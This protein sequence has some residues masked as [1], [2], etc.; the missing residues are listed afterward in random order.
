M[1]VKLTIR[2]FTVGAAHTI[3][4]APYENLKVSAEL[5]CSVPEDCTE[6][7]WF[8]LRQEAQGRLKELLRETYSNQKPKKSQPE[9]VAEK[10]T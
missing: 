7:Q 5:A 3:A 9:K 6:E 10:V 8:L 2:E 4:T 1:T